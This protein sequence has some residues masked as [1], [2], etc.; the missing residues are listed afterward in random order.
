MN[1]PNN[2][3][4]SVV[5]YTLQQCVEA[6]S[7]FN[8][9]EE[10]DVQSSCTL[11]NVGA[12]LSYVLGELFLESGVGNGVGGGRLDDGD[13]GLSCRERQIGRVKNAILPW[14][15]AITREVFATT[16]KQTTTLSILLYCIQ[17][18]RIAIWILRSSRRKCS[19][20]LADTYAPGNNEIH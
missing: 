15:D 7:V 18:S 12:S 13:S 5:A 14:S 19:T 2:D 8:F 9:T 6:C 11:T 20:S 3:I 4:S 10:Q 16:G 1:Y 17:P